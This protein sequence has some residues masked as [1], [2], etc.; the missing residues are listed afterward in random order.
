MTRKHMFE[1]M[2]KPCRNKENFAYQ[3]KRQYIEKRDVCWRE[4]DKCIQTDGT[5][6]KGSDVIEITAADESL[7][8]DV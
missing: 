4:D 1:V 3:M 5:V 6:I 7:F 8:A 2:V